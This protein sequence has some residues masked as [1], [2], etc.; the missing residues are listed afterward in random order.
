M[1]IESHR[2]D[3]RTIREG[4]PGTYVIRGSIHR[5]LGSMEEREGQ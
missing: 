1:A 2:A 5:M 3:E 4:I